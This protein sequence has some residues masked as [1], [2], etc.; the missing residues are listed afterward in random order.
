MVCIIQRKKQPISRNPIMKSVTIYLAS[1]PCFPAL[2]FRDEVGAL[3]VG[4]PGGDCSRALMAH[5]VARVV[6]N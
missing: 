5:E 3:R 2:G 6:E 4:Q 1:R